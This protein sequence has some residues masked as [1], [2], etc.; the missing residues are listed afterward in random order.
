MSVSATQGGHKNYAIYFVQ[1]EA[2]K[3]VEIARFCGVL[4]K[5]HGYPD[6]VIK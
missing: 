6:F 4:V 3:V 2:S 1:A 5:K